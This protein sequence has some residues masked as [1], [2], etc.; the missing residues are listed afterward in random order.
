MLGASDSRHIIS[1]ISLL[2][3][4]LTAPG[5]THVQLRKSTVVHS[6]TLSDIY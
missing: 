1:I 2:T 5:C 3:L 6:T 4:A